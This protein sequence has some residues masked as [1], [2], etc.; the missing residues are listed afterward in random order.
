MADMFDEAETPVSDAYLE[1]YVGEGKKFKSVEELAKAYANADKFIPELKNDLQT[2]REFIADKLSELAQRNQEPPAPV[3]IEETRIT[4]PDPVAPPNDSGEDLDT[5]IRKALEERDEEIR[6][7]K[8]AAL[9]EEVLIERLGSK[10]EAVKA[11]QTKAAELGVDP[12]Y[13]KNT[14]YQSPR[15]FFNLMGINPDEAPRSNSTPAPKS[16]VNPLALGHGQPKPNSYAYYDQLRKSD[17]KTYW[18]P[19][20]QAALMQDA[21]DNPDFFKR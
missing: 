7:R 15:A 8:N 1:Q 9:T 13:L 4:N 11:V 12:G 5:R 17:P 16:D 18:S 2:T 3:Q 19:K 20:T 10:E 14:A 21:Q 6:Y